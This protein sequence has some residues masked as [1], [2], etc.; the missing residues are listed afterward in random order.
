MGG[1]IIRVVGG[2]EWVRGFAV[3]GCDLLDWLVKRALRA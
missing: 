2:W 1:P 3:L